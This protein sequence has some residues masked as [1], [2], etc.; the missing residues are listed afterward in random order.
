MGVYLSIPNGFLGSLECSFRG[1][2]AK[3]V[4]GNSMGAWN[5]AHL[6]TNDPTMLIPLCRKMQKTRNKFQGM[7]HWKGGPKIISP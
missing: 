6:N 4:L 1:L 2:E 3:L 7:K 5:D